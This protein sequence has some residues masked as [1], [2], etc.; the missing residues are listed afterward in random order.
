MRFVRRGRDDRPVARTSGRQTDG[1]LALAEVRL[2]KL[3]SGP[4]LHVHAN[5]DEMFFVLDGLMT[6]RV[7]DQ[8]YEIAAGGLAWGARGIQH[9]FAN[10]ATDPAAHHDHVDSRRR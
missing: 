5:E 8:L 4:N 2:P 9:A 10:R 3:T 6:V 1:L 7:A